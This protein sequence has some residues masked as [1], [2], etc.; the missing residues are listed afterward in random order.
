MSDNESN[1]SEVLQKKRGRGHR[2]KSNDNSSKIKKISNKFKL[3]KKQKL[4]SPQINIIKP[5]AVKKT[6]IYN[7]SQSVGQ[8]NTTDKIFA[9]DDS[10][11]KKEDSTQENSL[12]QLTK[13][14]L[15]YIKTT[16]RKSINI[17]D[18]VNELSVKK[19]RIYDITNVL[20]GIDYLQKSGK[21]EIVWTK[22]ISIKAKSKKKVNAPKKNNINKQKINIEELEKEKNELDNDIDKFKAEFNSIA[23]KNDFAKYGYI[24]LEDIRRLSINAK[25]DLIVIKAAK[26]TVMNVIDKNDIK[27]A[28]DSAKNLMENN[29]MKSNDSL[30]NIL[31]KSNQLIF[32]CPEN[33]GINIYEIN[34]GN[35]KEIKTNQNNND[36]SNENNNS[37]VKIFDNNNN[38]PPK[39]FQN[40]IPFFN[41]QNLGVNNNSIINSNIQEKKYPSN[42][43]KGNLETTQHFFTANNKQPNIGISYTSQLQKNVNYN[44]KN[45]NIFSNPNNINNNLKEEKFS[46]NTNMTNL[47]KAN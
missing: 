31:N 11:M 33:V 43:E 47:N 25:V 9:D 14:F 32:T 30:L 18:L 5:K 27:Q 23:K 46:F 37:D 40:P 35:L 4:K 44:I 42:S 17:N 13:N 16:G 28:Y 2:S 45:H 20:Q 1:S 41:K 29:E 36:F 22:T 3:N 15:N 8:N 10:E 39:L 12:G 21:N 34:N 6:Y 26:G 38:N 19:R 7:T 24:T